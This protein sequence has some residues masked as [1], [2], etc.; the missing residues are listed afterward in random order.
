LLNPVEKHRICLPQDPPKEKP[1]PAET[2]S[3][4][5]LLDGDIFCSLAEARIAIES[6]RRHCNTVRPHGSPGYKPPDVTLIPRQ[7]VAARPE[8]APRSRSILQRANPPEQA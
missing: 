7:R 3:N 2:W 6:W 5:E 8:A 4:E 1:L